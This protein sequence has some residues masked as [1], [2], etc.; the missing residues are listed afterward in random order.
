MRV[1]VVEIKTESMFV[2]YVSAGVGHD[3]LLPCQPLFP[4]IGRVITA[5]VES[6]DGERAVARIYPTPDQAIKV[7]DELLLEQSLLSRQ[8]EIGGKWYRIKSVE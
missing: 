7:G 4:S 5:V 6:E 2:E 1:K 8:V 3:F